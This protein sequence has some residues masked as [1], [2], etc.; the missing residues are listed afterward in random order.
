MDAVSMCFGA[1]GKQ[2]AVSFDIDS[3]PQSDFII[4][5]GPDG[6]IFHQTKARLHETNAVFGF[7]IAV[8]AVERSVKTRRVR[9]TRFLSLSR[10]WQS[11]S[12]L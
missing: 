1:Y 9:V 4:P 7:C 3:V 6:H 11:S 2:V 8:G 10:F 5:S 12:V